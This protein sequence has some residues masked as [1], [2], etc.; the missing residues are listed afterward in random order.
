M[1]AMAQTSVA[2]GLGLMVLVLIATM[3]SVTFATGGAMAANRSITGALI[4]VGFT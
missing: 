2:I 4:A 1:R 3:L